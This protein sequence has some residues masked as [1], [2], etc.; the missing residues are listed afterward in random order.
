MLF[1]GAG[2]WGKLALENYNKYY[3]DSNEFNG[4]IDSKKKNSFNGIKVYSFEEFL[5]NYK[6]NEEVVITAHAWFAKEIYLKLR[7]NGIG[8]IYWYNSISL[9][10]NSS[11]IEGFCVP[12]NNWDENNISLDRDRIKDIYILKRKFPHIIEFRLLGGE[13][14][15]SD[16]LVDYINEVRKYYPETR[17][18]L[19]TNGLLISNLSYEKLKCIKDNNVIVSVTAYAP[20]KKIMKKIKDTLQE[21]GIHYIIN[22]EE[23]NIKF[24]KPL[25]ASN[26]TKLLKK[27]INEG[28]VNVYNGKISKCPLVMYIHK[29]NERF[30]VNFPTDGIYSLNDNTSAQELCEKLNK[31][32]PLCT[33]CVDN[34]IEWEKCSIQPLLDDWG[35]V[36]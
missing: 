29:L 10:K 15:L 13:P 35:S 18:E 36:E 4:Y 28:C 31:K 6:E 16:L 27:C 5:E 11:F 30:N 34:P 3:K 32:I 24:N 12:C 21:Y 17:L 1:Y 33:Y 20:T 26:S 2:L 8:N 9:N 19:F 23:E 7:E 22:L 25:S 14:L